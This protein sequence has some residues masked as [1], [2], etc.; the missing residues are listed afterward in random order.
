MSLKAR[1]KELVNYIDESEGK[2]KELSKQVE[3]LIKQRDSK[4]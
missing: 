3:Q 1:V 2:A 4:E